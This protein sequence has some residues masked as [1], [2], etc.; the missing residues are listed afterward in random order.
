MQLLSRDYKNAFEVNMSNKTRH[1][2]IIE[3]VEDIC[4]RVRIL[5]TSA[6]ASCNVA[7]HCNASEQK[8]KIIEIFDSVSARS[9]KKGDNVI[10]CISQGVGIRAVTIGF[11]LPFTVLVATLFITWEL[12]ANESVAA[13]AGI[14]ALLPYYFCVYIGRGKLRE[15][16]SFSIE[17]RN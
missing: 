16:L 10:V 8:E 2:G 11:V 17:N 9:Y 15:K 7:S 12:T 5:Q 14:C 4:V 13:I 6:C 1:A 3:S